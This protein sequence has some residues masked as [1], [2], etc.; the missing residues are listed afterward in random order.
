MNKKR[1]LKSIIGT[2]AIYGVLVAFLFILSKTINLGLGELWIFPVLC[3]VCSVTAGLLFKGKLY[4]AVW[5]AASVIF[6][7][8][9]LNWDYSVIGVGIVLFLAPLLFPFLIAKAIALSINEEKELSAQTGAT[10]TETQ[11]EDKEQSIDVRAMKSK[12]LLKSIIGTVVLHLVLFVFAFLCG[13]FT[14]AFPEF[15]IYAVVS[16]AC[17]FTAALLFKRQLN[18]WVWTVGTAIFFVLA[19]LTFSSPSGWDFEFFMLVVWLTLAPLLIP[20]FIVK[21]ISR[22]WN[23]TN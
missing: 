10:E 6:M 20:F 3:A 22:S 4:A 12:A 18:A 19:Y 11:T 1:L 7:S 9:M 13:I 17:S 2:V 23:R 15:G 5:S 16:I 8:F 21:G 14:N